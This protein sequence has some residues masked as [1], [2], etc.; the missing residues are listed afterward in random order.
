MSG[1]SEP[2]RLSMESGP[3][4]SEKPQSGGS[5]RGGPPVSPQANRQNPGGTRRRLPFCFNH[6]C[7]ELT[8]D[9]HHRF[10]KTGNMH[11]EIAR[12]YLPAGLARGEGLQGSTDRL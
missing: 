12:H 3:G 10:W 2:P 6:R 7:G 8:D 11:T 1:Y 4:G 9:A 5:A